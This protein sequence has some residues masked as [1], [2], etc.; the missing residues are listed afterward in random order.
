MVKLGGKV[1]SW[2]TRYF[3]LFPHALV[4][5]KAKEIWEKGFKALTVIPFTARTTLHI[6]AKYSN[7]FMLT[8]GFGERRFYFI[9]KDEL[10]RKL[11]M[12][13]IS[14]QIQSVERKD[15]DDV[16]AGGRKIEGSIKEGELLKLGATVKTWKKRY[17]V[18][19]DEKLFYF[20]SRDDK[21]P[22]GMIK[23]NRNWVVNKEPTKEPTKDQPSQPQFMFSMIPGDGGRLYY[24]AAPDNYDRGGWMNALKG[25]IIAQAPLL[26]GYLWKQ[27]A[28]RKS[29]QHRY[30]SLNPSTLSYYK[31]KKDKYPLGVISISNETVVHENI[32][33]GT[34]MF[35]FNLTS[36]KGKKESRTY[37]L[38]ATTTEQRKQW[39]AALQEAA[40]RKSLGQ[41]E[42][43]EIAA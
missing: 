20:K 41:K 37:L 42:E 32:I 23:F 40:R 14:A 39:L 38:A 17:F 28:L 25:Q 29:W 31:N 1:K 33:E 36:K 7:A 35:F 6:E 10:D 9:T 21:K 8:P 19:L 5:Y 11:W 30:F 3:V 22:V 27:G 24:F 34:Q 15:G 13:D 16:V 18:L 43:A 12:D 2:R 26:D 4:Y